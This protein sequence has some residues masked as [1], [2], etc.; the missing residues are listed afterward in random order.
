MMG[1]STSSDHQRLANS[2]PDGIPS[3]D[4][5]AHDAVTPFA[6][7]SAEPEIR[8]PAHDDEAIRE[9]VAA[10]SAGSH[11]PFVLHGTSPDAYG[12][13][14]S[15]EPFRLSYKQ[16]GGPVAL[17]VERHTV[18]KANGRASY[19]L[20]CPQSDALIYVTATT[21]ASELQKLA[22]KAWGNHVRNHVDKGMKPRQYME[23]LASLRLSPTATTEAG[24]TD[25][26]LRSTLSNP[27]R[28]YY[29]DIKSYRECIT[30]RCVELVSNSVLDFLHTFCTPSNPLS[31]VA[32]VTNG[33]LRIVIPTLHVYAALRVQLTDAILYHVRNDL[34]VGF[35]FEL[36]PL[37]NRVDGPAAQ[38]HG[39]KY[40]F[41]DCVEGLGVLQ[42]E[43]SLERGL[44][45]Y[46]SVTIQSL[47]GAPNTERSS[48]ITFKPSLGFPYFPPSTNEDGY[49]PLEHESR[50]IAIN[51]AL[52]IA[53]WTANVPSIFESKQCALAAPSTVDYDAYPLGGNCSH[54]PFANDDH[55]NRRVCIR[56]R[57]APP[58]KVGNM[59]MPNDAITIQI[60]CPCCKLTSE[61]VYLN[62]ISTE[63]RRTM[64]NLEWDGAQKYAPVSL[65]AMSN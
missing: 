58:R 46:Q 23:V 39:E 38:K 54:C 28:S 3:A 6:A 17:E 45:E 1:M 21:D 14:C 11:E 59:T 29:V 52:K 43:K 30:Q 56:I 61:K 18:Y 53:D 49:V 48:M 33:T 15:P 2:F 9:A 44:R 65:S 5:N 63:L 7:D 51:E 64:G 8:V 10:T 50:H 26:R 34:M 60:H 37:L 25:S 4:P 42:C 36:V 62:P 13:L 35:Y 12:H 22:R 24:N 19:A 47:S 27:N 55:P 20:T 40:H 16:V 31:C 57:E 32:G 41:L